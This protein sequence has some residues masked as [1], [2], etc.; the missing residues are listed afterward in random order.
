MLSK[1]AHSKPILNIVD[2]KSNAVIYKIQNLN[3][4][5]SHLPDYIITS[6]NTLL[7]IE[8]YFFC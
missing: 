4:L 3:G 1:N 6:K 2:N 8:T 7:C 5:N